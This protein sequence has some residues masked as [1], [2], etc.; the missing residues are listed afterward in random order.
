MWV[1]DNVDN[2][3]T[4]INASTGRVMRTIAVGPGAVGISA[5]G[6]DVWVANAGPDA[7]P[8]H[9]VTEIRRTPPRPRVVGH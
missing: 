4:E 1:A 3:V 9:T 5:D 7:K 6:S 2:S 8:G